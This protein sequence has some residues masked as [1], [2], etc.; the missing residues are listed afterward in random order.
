M[1]YR[2]EYSFSGFQANNPNRPLPGQEVDKELDALAQA[3]FDMAVSAYDLA[4]QQGFAGSVVEWL[5]TLKGQKGDKGDKGDQ[6]VQGP[7]GDKGDRGNTGST[8]AKGDKGDPGAQGPKGDVGPQGNTG[9][10]GAQG[11][12][13]PQGAKGDTGLQGPKGDKGDTGATGAKGDQ[14]IQGVTGAKGDQGIQGVKGD[15]GA[16][17]APGAKGDKGDTGD[18]GPQGPQG[19]GVVIKGSVPTPADLPAAG[20]TAGDT[21]IVT[22]SGA[23]FNAGDGY[24][25]AGPANGFVNVGQIRGPQGIQGPAGPAGAKGDTG[26]AGAKG[27]QGDPGIQGPK[28]DT[29]AAGAQGIQGIQGP[30]GDTGAAG[31][32]GIQGPKGDQGIQGVKGD[33]GAA[34]AKGDTGAQGIQ[35]IQGVKGDK[36]DTGAQG[37]K[38][39]TGATGPAGSY[40]FTPVQQGT[41]PGQGGNTVSFGWGSDTNADGNAEAIMK[42]SVDGTDLGA[43]LSDYSL[44]GGNR[45]QGRLNRQKMVKF[46]GAGLPGAHFVDISGNG[47]GWVNPVNGFYKLGMGTKVSDTENLWDSTNFWYNVPETGLYYCAA[48]LRWRD[49]SGSFEFGFGLDVAEQDGN[50]FKWDWRPSVTRYT[51]QNINI[52]RLVVGQQIRFVMYPTFQNPSAPDSASARIYLIKPMA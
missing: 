29:G 25:Y 49:S 47:A 27:D 11:D 40:G 17:G 5:A 7:K 18:Q 30:K 21:Y 38:G 42:S 1:A 6:G 44:A 41:G 4:V 31:A 12:T 24:A 48:A 20:N 45:A 10:R 33:T 2:R 19:A 16:Q 8:G 9:S 32:Q 36:G 52:R 28:G 50:Y 51:F 43:V 35:G 26:A 13:G 14:G 34:G 23:G 3:V 46:F 39:D 15:T 22:T 37:P